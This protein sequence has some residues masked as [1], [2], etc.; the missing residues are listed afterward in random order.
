[1]PHTV[2]QYKNGA[3]FLPIMSLMEEYKCTETRLEMT[4]KSHDPCVR[5]AAPTLNTE[6]KWNPGSEV[7]DTKAVLKHRDIVGQV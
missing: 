7:A 6:R 1:M 2:G 5:D 3:L 4:F